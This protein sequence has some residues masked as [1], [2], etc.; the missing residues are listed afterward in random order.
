MSALSPKQISGLN[1]ASLSSDQIA[2]LSSA[3]VSGL[4]AKQLTD[5]SSDQLSAM[6]ATQVKGLTA[7]QLSSVK[8]VNDLSLDAFSA[9]SST[10]LKGL[11]TTTL[12]HSLDAE[13]V[14]AVITKLSPIQIAKLTDGTDGTDATFFRNT[15][16]QL[17]QLS[18]VDLS[19]MSA[20]QL[21]AIPLGNIDKLDSSALGATTSV[22][23]QF[24][25]DQIKKLTG[26]SNQG[27]GQIGSLSVDTIAKLSAAQIKAFGSNSNALTDSQIGAISATI[28]RP[29]IPA[30]ITGLQ[31]ASLTSYKGLTD[32]QVAGLTTTQIP[33]LLLTS[34]PTFKDISATGLGQW[35]GAQVAA[36]T[37]ALAGNGAGK[38]SS[39]QIAILNPLIAGSTTKLIP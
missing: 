9:L 8:N 26:G 21:Q 23:Q 13:H 19:A 29:G 28:I 32:Q 1:V 15:G 34:S 37:T 30:A 25:T 24:T 38:F 31:V 35:S 3:Q 6:S 16:G 14:S 5:L 20:K 33:K 12:V 7:T 22:V 27:D 18:S 4:S 11:N 36:L 17:G 2:A 39:N 10:Q